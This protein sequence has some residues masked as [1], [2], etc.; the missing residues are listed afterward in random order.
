MRFVYLVQHAYL[1]GR[2]NE[3]EEAKIIGIFD[4][5][6]KANEIIQIYKDLPGF[7]DFDEECFTVDKYEINKGEWSEGFVENL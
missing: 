6:E 5:E 7:R 1:Y 4:C 2:D 3:H